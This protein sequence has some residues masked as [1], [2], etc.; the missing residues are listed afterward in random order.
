MTHICLVL[1]LALVGIVPARAEGLICSPSQPL[2][3]R[4]Q[5]P[6]QAGLLLVWAG[7]V[8]GGTTASPDGSYTLQ[9]TVGAEAPG[10]YPVQVR[11]RDGHALVLDTACTVPDETL[12]T[13]TSAP[14]TPPTP[15]PLPPTPV[16]ESPTLAAVALAAPTRPATP[17]LTSVPVLSTTVRLRA[18]Y[19]ANQNGVVDLDEGIRGLQVY[20][21]DDLGLL[22]GD[23]VTDERGVAQIPI[24]APDPHAELSVTIPFFSVAQTVPATDPRPQPVI[25]PGPAALPAVLP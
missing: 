24:A 7:R 22:L 4:G 6:A 21:S 3:L 5:A 16:A 1:L 15:T 12:P 11:L 10:I 17:T 20:V 19:D 8:V 25:I 18:G 14:T 9:L 2:T 23:G 13:P